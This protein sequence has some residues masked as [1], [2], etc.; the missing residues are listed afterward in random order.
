MTLYSRLYIGA[1]VAG[2]L[3]CFGFAMAGWTCH[4]YLHFICLLAIALIGS[5]LKVFLPGISG[6]MSAS[7][8]FVLVSMIDFG[9]AETTIVA[10]SAAAVQCFWRSKSRPKLVKLLFSLARVT[11]AVLIASA[12][13]HSIAR[14]ANMLL[15]VAIAA[16][17]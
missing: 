6:T 4:D 8:V 17:V 14:R 13:Y 12:P 2:G 9:R 3:V 7:F 5:C 15:S 1:S 16:I 11:L 10:C